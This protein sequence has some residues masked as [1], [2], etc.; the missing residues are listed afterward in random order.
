M[1]NA[2]CRNN[3]KRAAL[4]CFVAFHS[5][6]FILAS[7]SF[8]S[9]SLQR[10]TNVV[11]AGTG[12]ISNGTYFLLGSTNA[13]APLINWTIL[14]STNL[15]DAGGNFSFTHAASPWPAACFFAIYSLSRADTI[16]LQALQNVRDEGF[17][18]YLPPPG[19]LWVNWRYTNNPPVDQSMGNINYDG[20]PDADPTTRHDRLTDIDYL[21]ALCLYK[22]LHPQDPQFD[23]EINRY[24]NIIQSPIG[25]HFLSSPDQRGW[26]YWAIEDITSVVPS[27]VALKNAQADKFY[28]LF[29]NHLSRFGQVMPLYW[30]TPGDE[31]SGTYRGDLLV[32]DACVLI[33]NGHERSLTNYVLAG[34]ALMAYAQS[35]TY[36][37][38]L[39]MWTDTMGHLFT[40][41]AQTTL[42]PPGQQY[43]YDAT[44]NTSEIGEILDAICRAEA[45]DPG[46]GYGALA[47]ATLNKLVPATNA[48]GLWDTTHGGYYSNLILNGTNIHSAGLTASVNASYKQVGRAAVMIQAYLSANRFAGGNYDTSTLTAI[49]TANLNSYYAAGHGWPFQE[50]NDYSLYLD[51]ITSPTNYYVPQTWVTSEAISHATRALLTYQLAAP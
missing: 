46:K 1:K 44:V 10:G 43:I 16:I 31:L 49:N 21:A 14:S 34:E 15:F 7:P 45:A 51:H 27:F 25:D 40:D 32:E 30:S 36:S 33:V 20:T 3:F 19:G 12:G 26:V 39:Q 42:A 5:S 13:S 41:T 11:V 17:N 50:K 28:N 29:T 38:T 47:Q 2:A 22:K 9:I 4:I 48:F 18:T 8:S 35:N 24:T 37:A 23:A 6:F